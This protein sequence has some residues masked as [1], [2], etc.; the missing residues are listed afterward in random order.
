[1]DFT[2]PK[3]LAAWADSAG[4]PLFPKSWLNAFKREALPFA[5]DHGRHKLLLAPL[6]KHGCFGWGSVI[7]APSLETL[8]ATCAETGRPMPEQSPV[9]VELPRNFQINKIWRRG[10]TLLIGPEHVSFDN[11][12]QET[13]RLSVKAPLETQ[14]L[15]PMWLFEDSYSVLRKPTSFDVYDAHPDWAPGAK[16]FV[17]KDKTNRNGHAFMVAAMSTAHITAWRG[18]FPLVN[19]IPQKE[20]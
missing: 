6:H 2:D 4:A 12:L 14:G 17:R 1:M 15:S 5:S 18:K 3:Q 16:I 13:A 20:A 19:Y 8:S 11:G 10:A 7:G 9:Y